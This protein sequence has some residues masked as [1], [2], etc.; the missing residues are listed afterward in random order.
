MP[1]T[2]QQEDAINA[3][4]TSIIV[5]AAA[6]SGKTA[7]LTERISKI[8]ADPEKGVRADRIIIVTFTNDAASERKKRLERNLSK[9]INDNPSDKY[10]LE[11]QVH[12]KN[13]K[14]C[15]INSFCFD[16]IRDNI[17][18]QGVT[19]GFTV[20]DDIDNKVLKSQAM[21]DLI[22]YYCENENDK[23]SFLYD[24]FCK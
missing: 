5:S 14:I 10:L 8:I 17:E 7:V 1:W 21:D 4:N 6:G 11:Q 23:I 13:A 3:E 12:L 2:Q 9:L 18:E 19:S 24:K 22:D 20:L 15:T 16:L